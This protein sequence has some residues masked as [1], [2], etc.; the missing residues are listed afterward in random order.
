MKVKE[1]GQSTIEF[2]MTFGVVFSLFFLFLK[3]AVNFTD[4]YMVHHA[5]YMASRSYLV[6]DSENGASA[7]DRDRIAFEY[8]NFVF[9]KYLPEALIQNFNGTLKQN[10]P[11]V[12]KYA[13]FVGLHISYSTP[14]SWG[15]F[16]GK[17][18]LELRSESFLGRE[19]SRV[20]VYDQI[21]NAVIAV[22]GGTCDFQA[23]LDDN[24]G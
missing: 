6:V 23:T 4:G 16:G 11:N 15:M 3:M 8:A 17:E 19:P 5:V 2:I 12:V 24:G 14:F 7:E 1:E 20:E 10:A 21:C 13:P 9:K 18:Q 22:T